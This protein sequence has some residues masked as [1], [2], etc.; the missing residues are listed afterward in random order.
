MRF[1]TKIVFLWLAIY[2]AILILGLLIGTRLATHADLHLRLNDQFC[3]VYSLKGGYRSWGAVYS[4]GR[5]LDT[6][7]NLWHWPVFY[8]NDLCYLEAGIP[9]KP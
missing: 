3:C 6:G 1:K 2:A 8:H 7:Q 5:R 9:Q 4:Y